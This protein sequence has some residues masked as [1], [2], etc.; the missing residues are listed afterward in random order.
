[1]VDPGRGARGALYPQKEREREREIE[2]EGERERERER[3]RESTT[4][5]RD[6]CEDGSLISGKLTEKQ[7]VKKRIEHGRVDR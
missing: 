3:E 7:K 1:M 5:R 4:R 6:P 2:R